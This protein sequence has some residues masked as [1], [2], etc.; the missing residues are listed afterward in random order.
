MVNGIDPPRESLERRKVPLVEK[1]VEPL[2]DAT[3]WF[4]VV[5]IIAC[6]IAAVPLIATLI[7]DWWA[8]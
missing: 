6:I 8:P 2:H 3:R 5:G 7:A 4:L 1:P